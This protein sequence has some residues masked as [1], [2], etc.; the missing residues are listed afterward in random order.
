MVYKVVAVAGT[1][2]TDLEFLPLAAHEGAPEARRRHIT[3]A[4]ELELPPSINT[5]PM[6]LRRNLTCFYCGGKSELKKAPHIRQFDCKE[7]EATNYLDEVCPHPFRPAAICL[8]KTTLT[9]HALQNG[10]ITDPPVASSAQPARFAHYVPARSPSPNLSAPDHNLF[11]A[12][13]LKNQHLLTQTLAS[14]LPPPSDPSYGAFERSYPE[15]RRNL[16]RRYP[17]VCA[18][19]APR[20][21]E[22]I[23]QAGYAAKTDYLKRLLDRP[24]RDVEKR[25]YTGPTWQ[26]VL[27]YWAGWLW[28]LSVAIHFAWSV[29]GVFA[30]KGR[31]GLGRDEYALNAVSCGR[32]ARKYGEVQGECMPAFAGEMKF[33][34][35]AMAATFWWNNKLHAKVKGWTGGRLLG[36]RNHLAVQAMMLVLRAG[37]WWLLQDP[38][39]SVLHQQAYRGAHLFVALLIFSV[40]LRCLSSGFV[41]IPRQTTIYSSVV[42]QVDRTPIFSMKTQ[43]VPLVEEPLDESPQKPNVFYNSP[44]P[45]QNFQTQSPAYVK[46]FPVNHM[47]QPLQMPDSP[48]SP[49]PSFSTRYTA[50]T[51][52]A[53]TR[54]YDEDEDT[55]EWTPTR[56]SQTTFHD[57]RPRN[58]PAGQRQS[59]QLQTLINSSKQN[60]P[61]PFRGTLP[62]A[63]IGPAHRLRNP[64]NQR[65]FRKTPL[66]KQK[67]FFSKLM[68]ANNAAGTNTKPHPDEDAS[69]IVDTEYRLANMSPNQLQKRRIEMDF[70]EPKLHLPPQHPVDTGLE[71]MFDSVFSIRD[72]PEE[73]QRQRAIEREQGHKGGWV[74][75]AW[76]GGGAALNLEQPTSWAVAGLAAAPF[77]VLGVVFAW[78]WIGGLVFGGRGEEA[79]GL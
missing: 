69:T 70:A 15:Y 33:A 37:S 20:V 50:F 16:E 61:S 19:C 7:C 62:P 63:P 42:V 58:N 1:K 41:L 39:S 14:Y 27:V 59:Q 10:E 2:R 18:A 34:I 64:P 21:R 65:T 46:P 72:E 24:R 13:C 71:A 79:G 78:G 28:W 45:K 30:A 55:M 74:G 49:T 25:Y 8:Q 52:E 60:E 3:A 75:E 54:R 9:W 4:A 66:A 76:D 35:L 67:D 36:L 31:L 11:C 17:P 77:A 73:V 56:P 12:T 22:R 26:S 38:A 68:T 32:Q 5:M 29:L 40:S 51:T 57:L 6:L 23:Q 43:E 53:T 44:A 47:A 48:P